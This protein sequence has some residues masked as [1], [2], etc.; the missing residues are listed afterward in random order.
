MSHRDAEWG[1]TDQQPKTLAELVAVGVVQPG[2]TAL[3]VV[4]Q[5][6]AAG[7]GEYRGAHRERLQSEERQALER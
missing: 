6:V 7:A 1:I 4:R 2:V 5:D 3:A